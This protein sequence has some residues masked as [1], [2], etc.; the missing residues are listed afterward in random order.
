M[1]PEILIVEKAIQAPVEQWPG[2]C[3]VVAVQ[4]VANDALTKMGLVLDGKP[5]TRYGHWLGPVAPG[6]MFSG[7]PVVPH[8]WIEV[9]RDDSEEWIVDPTRWVFEGKDPYI[10]YGPND[11]YDIGGSDLRN[12]MRSEQP[13]ACGD[14]KFHYP[15]NFEHAGY[16]RALLKCNCDEGLMNVAQLFWIGNIDYRTLGDMAIPVYKWLE[17]INQKAIVP[18]DYWEKVMGI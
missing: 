2:N 8:G 6:N 11:Y 9:P 17:D 16:V 7:K 15:A 4:M 14:G 12:A 3:H 5:V 10:Y 13:P 1:D 18:L